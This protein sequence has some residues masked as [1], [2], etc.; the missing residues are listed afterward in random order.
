MVEL[1]MGMLDFCC[2]CCGLD[3]GCGDQTSTWQ[4]GSVVFHVA[5]L[6]ED[7]TSTWH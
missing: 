4:D 7:F 3:V 2:V 1:M 5:N 6:A